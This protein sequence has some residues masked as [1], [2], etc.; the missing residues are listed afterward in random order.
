VILKDVKAQCDPKRDGATFYGTRFHDAAYLSAKYLVFLATT[1]YKYDTDYPLDFGGVG[2]LDQDPG[3][4]EYRYI[5]I[6]DGEPTTFVNDLYDRLEMGAEYDH[7]IEE[8][9]RV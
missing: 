5:V 9:S 6:A 1:G 8:K 3:D 4:I 2:I 7:L